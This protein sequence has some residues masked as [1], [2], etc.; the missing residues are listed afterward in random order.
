MTKKSLLMTSLIAII[1]Y[2]VCLKAVGLN[3]IDY[4]YLFASIKPLIPHAL[5]LMGAFVFNLLAYL[6]GQKRM[7]LGA[8]IFC[9][10]AVVSYVPLS[11][12]MIIPLGF[13]LLAYTKP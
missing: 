4:S 12:V 2:I 5:T 11:L 6:N 10:L 3:N 9:F 13:V 1:A 8:G 7:I